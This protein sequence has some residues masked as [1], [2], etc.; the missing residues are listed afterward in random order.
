[1]LR[2]FFG[3]ASL[4]FW[5]LAMGLLPLSDANALSFVSPVLVAL[6]AP[7][8]LGQPTPRGEHLLVTGASGRLV[9]LHPACSSHVSQALAVPCL[10]GAG[11]GLRAVMASRAVQPSAAHIS[12]H[13]PLA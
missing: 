9:M 2:G 4:S 1:L 11:G 13:Q 5:Y 12:H 6:M 3:F 7:S 8:V 10:E